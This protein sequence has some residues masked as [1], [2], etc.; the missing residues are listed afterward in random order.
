LSSGDEQGLR[1]ALVDQLIERGR[2]TTPQVEAALRSV[3]RH[4]FLPEHE[5]AAAYADEAVGLKWHRGR[6]LSS[7]SQPSMIAAMLEMLDVRAGS[8]VLEIGTGSGYNAALLA[9]LAGTGGHVVSVEV[10]EQ[11]ATKAISLLRSA[12]FDS[13]DV[14]VGD[15]RAGWPAGAPYDRIIVTA[16]SPGPEESWVEQLDEGGRMT[17]PLAHEL[18]AVVFE[19][20]GGRL[21][22][23][24]SCPALFIPLR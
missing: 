4:A 1:C 7:V 16:S 24:G 20:V 21:K 13:V 22:R 9:T 19:K 11:L 6:P 12:G 5:L 18:E 17:V 2:V 10:D 8:R 15:G 3:P 23:R 14:Q